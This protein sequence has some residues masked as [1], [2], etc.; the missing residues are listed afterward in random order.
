MTKTTVTRI[1]LTMATLFIFAG[2]ALAEDEPTKPAC[3]KWDVTTV[4]TVNKRQSV[5]LYMEAVHWVA[6]KFTGE[7][8]VMPCI[9]VHVGSSCPDGAVGNLCVSP[10]TGDLYLPKWQ[11]DSSA[12]I[13]QATV[14][15]AMMQLVNRDEVRKMAGLLLAADKRDF[16]DALA[17][18]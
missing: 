12:A 17:S 5:R 18:K 11:E 9:T 3:L 6:S 8:I 2:I 7:T 13:A 10:V 15:T 14:M 16:Y 1:L 4:Q